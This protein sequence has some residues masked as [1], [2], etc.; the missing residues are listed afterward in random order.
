MQQDSMVIQF[1]QRVKPICVSRPPPPKKKREREKIFPQILHLLPYHKSPGVLK[2][3][4]TTSP[5]TYIY[6]KESHAN[7]YDQC[8]PPSLPFPFSFPIPPLLSSTVQS[9][10]VRDK[11]KTFLCQHANLVWFIITEPTHIYTYLG[12]W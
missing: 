4:G 6:G 1:R 5:G 3:G 9:S 12:T 7:I 10:K 11:F 8:C 2:G